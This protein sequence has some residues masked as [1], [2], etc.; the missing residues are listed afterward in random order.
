MIYVD[1]MGNTAK[2]SHNDFQN[3][4]V[5]F[6]MNGNPEIHILPYAEFVER[7]KHLALEKQCMT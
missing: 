5:F 6:E 2:I 3:N 7:F 4:L 1:D